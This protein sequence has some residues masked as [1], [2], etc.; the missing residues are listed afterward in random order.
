MV[1]SPGNPAPTTPP[2]LE[3]SEISKRFGGILALA[4]LSFDVGR[5]EAVGIVGPNGAGKTTLFNC[6]LGLEDL[7]TGTVVFDGVR[8]DR[9]PIWKRSRMGIGRTYQRMELFAGMT[10]ADHL[11]VAEQAKAGTFRLW[12]D[13]LHRGGPTAAELRHVEEVLE[14]LG[15]TGLA[16]RPVDGLDLGHA[17]LVEVGRALMGA[18][19]LLMLDEPSSGLDAAETERLASILEDVRGAQGT[20]VVLVEHDLQLVET[21]V[22]RLFVLNFGRMLTSGPVDEVLA[23][24]EV[25]LAYLGTSG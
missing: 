21:L 19:R 11:L 16:D 22:D 1:D 25:R 14:L 20:A 5:G 4:E 6:L 18:P 15:L 3:A 10:V 12:R 23:S 24:P 9:L 13:L 7:D 2:L 17:R 8:I